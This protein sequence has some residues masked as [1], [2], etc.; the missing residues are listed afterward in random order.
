M[1][2]TYCK[3]LKPMLTRQYI[4]NIF[5]NVSQPHNLRVGGLGAERY[6]SFKIRLVQYMDHCKHIFIDLGV[7]SLYS[8]CIL[9]SLTNLKL[10]LNMFL[11]RNNQNSYSTQKSGYFD[12]PYLGSVKRWTTFPIYNYL[13]EDMKSSSYPL[14]KRSLKTWL[15]ACSFYSS[16]YVGKFLEA[17]F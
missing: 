2:F 9:T 5:W 4:L 3:G 16:E 8:H 10:I 1:Y 7:L 13:P 14:F 11:T 12:L 15:L 17:Q 6:F